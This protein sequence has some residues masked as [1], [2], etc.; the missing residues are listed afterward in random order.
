MA[1]LLSKI[2]PTR[3]PVAYVFILVVLYQ[4][5][6]KG[7]SL[8]QDGIQYILELLGAVT[9]RQLVT[10]TTSVEVKDRDV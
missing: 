6:I 10:P 8:S 2:K 1:N 5:F 3:E 7:D 4:L 9:A